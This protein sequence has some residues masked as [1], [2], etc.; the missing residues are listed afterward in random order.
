MQPAFHEIALLDAKILFVV[1]IKVLDE[2]VSFARKQL[3]FVH[4]RELADPRP[5]VVSELAKVDLV[6][7]A[8][9]PDAGFRP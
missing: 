1:Q 9:F 2:L 7:V 4:F 8:H 3:R 6:P 5:E